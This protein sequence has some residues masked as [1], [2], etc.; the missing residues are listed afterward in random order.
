MPQR[1]RAFVLGVPLYLLAI[2]GDGLTGLLVRNPFTEFT[3]HHNIFLLSF[4]CDIF[5]HILSI[6]ISNSIIMK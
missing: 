3:F 1:S 2:L 4:S 6:V 5:E